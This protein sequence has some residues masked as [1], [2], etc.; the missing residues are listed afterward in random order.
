MMKETENSDSQ[1]WSASELT[2]NQLIHATGH[3]G[4]LSAR[5]SHIYGVTQ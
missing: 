1:L 4:E 5:L 2:A 3:A